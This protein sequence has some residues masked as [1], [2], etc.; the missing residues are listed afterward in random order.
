VVVVLCNKN[1]KIIHLKYSWFVFNLNY[2]IVVVDD[3]LVEDNFVEDSLV[4]GKLVVTDICLGIVGVCCPYYY[5]LLL[6]FKIKLKSSF[7]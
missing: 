7:I 1:K 5:F 6:S 3:N 4:V 2:H